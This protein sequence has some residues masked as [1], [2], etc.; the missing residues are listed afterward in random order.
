MQRIVIKIGSSSIVNHDAK[1]LFTERMESI[2]EDISWLRKDLKHEVIL[3][4]SG[5]LAWGRVCMAASGIE[6]KHQENLQMA[7]ACGQIGIAAAWAS[8]FRKHSLVIGQLLLDHE[9]SSSTIV[10]D[11]IIK[12]Q[13]CGMIPY[14]NEN[15][16]TMEHYDNDALAA[17]VACQ[18]GCDTLILLSDVDGVYSANP[19]TDSNAYL[20]PQIDDIDEA[21]IKYAEK[22]STNL[23]T[24]G[25]ISKLKAAKTMSEI[26]VKTIIAS[27]ECLNPLREIIN[28]QGGTTIRAK[29]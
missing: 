25:M 29:T 22:S 9:N 6:Y 27:G 26:G 15:I 20:I 5:A 13:G 24:G 12:M 2:A 4:S 21:L 17:E 10:R 7:G 8:A 23:G 11:T 14:I 28:A 16:P 3:M 19:K 18:T 1:Y